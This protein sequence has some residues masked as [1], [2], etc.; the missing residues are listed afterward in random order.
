MLE[1]NSVFEDTYRVE[2]VIGQGGMG[3]VY[4]AKD[5]GDKSRWAI[6]E[7][8]VTD[9]NRE[10]LFSEAEILSRLV[11]PALPALRM[12]KQI[13]D[14]LYIVMEYIEGNTLEDL[15]K[16]YQQFEEPV[17]VDWFRQ[18]CRVLVYLH[19]IDPPIVY[20]DLKPSNI[21]LDTSGR[22]RIIDFGIAQEYSPDESARVKVQALT[23]G[24]AAPEQYSRRYTLDVRTDIYALG[25]TM[26]YLL[27]GKDPNVPPYHFRPARKL[28]PDA[29]PA[30]EHI[31]QKCLQPSPDRRYDSA[32]QLLADLDNIKELDKKLRSAA[33]AR[34]ILIAAAAVLIFAAAGIVY[35]VNLRGRRDSIETYYH[36]LEQAEAAGELDQALEQTDKAIAL[37]PDNPDAYILRADLYL[38]FDRHEEA[39]DYMEQEIV[40]RFPDI[41][42]DPDFQ[43]LIEHI[44]AQQ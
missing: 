41:Y 37:A 12:K 19:G 8:T 15:R 33:A 16:Q 27:T 35:F 10:L 13:G 28:R 23:R 32:E 36:F 18:V 24:Y 17:I 30:I 29:S 2:K 1:I 4:L 11:H 3:R 20:R 21:M 6:K 31:L 25:V 40:P 43:V 42:S 38:R 34:K 39:V 9:A 14:K 44:E 26:H 22:I 7:Q 5:V